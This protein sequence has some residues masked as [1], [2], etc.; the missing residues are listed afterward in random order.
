MQRVSTLKEGDTFFDRSHSVLRVTQVLPGKR[1]ALCIRWE[2]TNKADNGTLHL[3]PFEY[4]ERA[5]LS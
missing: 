1:G 4:V 2:T 5:V 3:Q